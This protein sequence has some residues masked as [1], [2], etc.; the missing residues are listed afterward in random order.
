MERIEFGDNVRIAVTPATEEAGVAGRVGQVYGETTPSVTA[1]Q[2]IGDAHGDYAINVFFKDRN[3]SL[4]FSSELLE[5]VDHG[6]GTIVK[7]GDKTFV[8]TEQ[9]EWR[10]ESPQNHT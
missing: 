2:V 5:F 1:V 3:E 8:R 10:E 7:S 6:P 4:W 9:G